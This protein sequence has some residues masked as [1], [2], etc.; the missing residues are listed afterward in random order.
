MDIPAAAYL[1]FGFAAAWSHMLLILK[2][3]EHKRRKREDE[4]VY[5]RRVQAELDQVAQRIRDEYVV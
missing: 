4:A 3:E 5:V 2:W 1:M